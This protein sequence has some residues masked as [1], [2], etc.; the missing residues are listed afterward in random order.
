MFWF[1]CV[2][3]SIQPLDTAPLANKH[4][5]TQ[6]RLSENMFFY[7]MLKAQRNMGPRINRFKPIPHAEGATFF[8]AT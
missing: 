2:V 7:A 5:L 4:T 6:P 8:R 3:I 1:T